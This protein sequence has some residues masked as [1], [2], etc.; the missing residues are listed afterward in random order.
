M[1][2]RLGV[3][4]Q[5]VVVFVMLQGV[6]RGTRMCVSVCAY[7]SVSDQMSRESKGLD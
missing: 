1:A 2:G 6:F 5:G 7:F 3:F 4:W